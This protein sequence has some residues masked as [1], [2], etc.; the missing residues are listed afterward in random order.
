ME[1]N[2]RTVQSRLA[3]YL[4]GELTGSEHSE[5]EKHL[6]SCDPCRQEYESLGAV[7]VFLGALPQPPEV[8]AGF[9]ERVLARAARR[10][11][12]RF[13]IPWFRE[14]MSPAMSLAA[15][16]MLV[17]GIGLGAL[18]GLD[19]AVDTGTGSGPAGNDP[20][21][22]YRFDYLSETPDGSLAGAYLDLIQSAGGGGE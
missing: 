7:D 1:M 5:I 11:E 9:A 6:R 2:C 16:A 15:A 13:P 3:R 8:P 12:R 14:V 17:L 22:A 21:T 19:L 10:P 18:M 4:D 20:G